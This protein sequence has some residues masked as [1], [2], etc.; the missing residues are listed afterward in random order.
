[1]VRQLSTVYTTQ[2]QD[3][4]ARRRSCPQSVAPHSKECRRR[5]WGFLL[6]LKTRIALRMSSKD[7]DADAALKNIERQLSS[8]RRFRRIAGALKSMNNATLTKVEIVTK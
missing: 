1:M 8:G 7:A 3:T 5:A 6:E 4:E 2:H